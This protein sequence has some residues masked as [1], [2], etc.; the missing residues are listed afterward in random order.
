MSE[1]VEQTPYDGIIPT[2]WLTAYGRAFSDI[3]Y[4][5][6]IFDELEAIRLAE[7]GTNETLSVMKDTNL[8]PQ[9][10]ARHKLLNKLIGQ[11]GVKQVLE[12]AAGLSTRGIETT[13]DD[14]FEYV[15]LDLPG[16]MADKRKIVQKLQSVGTLPDRSNL[17]FE[18]GSAVEL[19]DFLKAARHFDEGKPV[20]IMNEG[21]L[22]YLSFDEKAQYAQNVR[23]LLERFGGYWITSDISLPKVLYKEDDVMAERRKK[24]SAITGVN[25]AENLFKDEEDAKKYFEELGFEVESH[26]FLE[27]VDELTSPAKLDM[28]RDYVEAING[29]A[30]CFVMRLKDEE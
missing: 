18:N 21:L 2:G 15:E 28:P 1:N 5:Q 22:R 26:S 12:I 19:E 27:V 16:M 9:F 30:V 20:V 14:E 4:A 8:A 23:A 25:V 17:H 3:P 13:A 10:E 24:I 6:A 11:T 7:G 29:S